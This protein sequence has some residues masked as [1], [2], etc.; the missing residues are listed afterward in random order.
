MKTLFLSSILLVGFTVFL[1]CQGVK[2]ADL[3]DPSLGAAAAVSYRTENAFP[4]LSFD[5]PVDLT[6]PNDNTNRL[7]AVAQSGLIRVFANRPDVSVATVFLDIQSKVL[8]SGEM[9]LLGLAFHPSY[10]QNGFF[11]VNYNPRNSSETI[12]SRFKVNPANPNQADPNSEVILFRFNQPYSNHNGGSMQFGPDGFLYVASGDGG[13][14]G[15]PQNNAQNLTTLLG[16]IL[17]VDVN[18]TDRGNYGIPRDNPYRGNTQGYREEI[19]AY[20]LRN[21]WRMSFDRNTRTLWAGDVGQ[22]ARE[23]IDIIVRGGNYGWR[24]KEGK[25]CYNPATNCTQTGQI[26]PILDYVQTNGDRSVTGGYVYRGRQL[27]SLRGKYIY[28]DFVS[29]RI[30]ALTFSGNRLIS[31]VQIASGAGNIS[32]FGVDAND[33]LYFCDYSSRQIK[34]IVAQSSTVQAEN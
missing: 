23:E 26:D 12:I 3:D 21:P 1:S 13:S 4:G 15:D 22:N 34:K 27:S 11:Y 7:F 25:N 6:T 18:A 5:S 30:W 10:R 19:F 16:K 8:S 31:N 14:G 32:A 2:E 9:G 17:R 24:M 33:E 20:G 29:G 28:G